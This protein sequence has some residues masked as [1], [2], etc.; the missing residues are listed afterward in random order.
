MSLLSLQYISIPFIQ[1]ASSDI[2]NKEVHI[3]TGNY[4]HIKA[5]SGKGKSSLIHT[6]YGL[7]K[8]Y[9]GDLLIENINVKQF[10]V[11]EWC[12]VRATKMSIVFQ[13][14]KL[15]EDQ[16][17]FENIEIK[18]ELTSYYSNEK[19]LE[20]ATRLHIA[21]ALGRTVN[22]LSYGE[23]QRVAIVRALMQDFIFLLLD[24]PFSHL[25]EENIILATELIL[26]ETKK[27]NAAL[28]LTDLE[29]DDRFPYH[30]KLIL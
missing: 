1:H 23:R 16:T 13:D 15:F 11:D 20:F 21:H 14:L 24:E 7:Q 29:D 3:E 18:R 5:A 22:T 9:D 8:N 30:Q 12:D 10:A 26:E 4:Y 19:I 28:L 17:A 25:D 27:R 6:I 2:W